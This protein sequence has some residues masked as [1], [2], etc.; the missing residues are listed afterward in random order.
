MFTDEDTY[1]NYPPNHN[2]SFAT[3]AKGLEPLLFVELQQLHAQSVRQTM[4]G[5]LLEGDVQLAYRFCLWTRLANRLLLSL[6]ETLVRRVQD[7]P[8]AVATTPWEQVFDTI[9][10]FVVDFNGR[11]NEIR[12]TQF[13]A[14]LI[15]DGIVDRFRDVGLQRPSVA[16]EGADIRIHAHIH[17]DK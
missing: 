1:M 15:K 14:Q 9:N 5:C 17:K 12:H 6:G 11:S 2:R 16:K 8:Q 10:T 3:C 7:I 13:G 4:G